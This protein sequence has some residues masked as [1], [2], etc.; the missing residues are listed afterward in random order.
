[1]EVP[2]AAFFRGGLALAALD[3]VERLAPF[4]EPRLL[5]R[6]EGSLIDAPKRM[7]EIKDQVAKTALERLQ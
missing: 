4:S 5:I 7:T 1:M 6:E 3:F 2:N